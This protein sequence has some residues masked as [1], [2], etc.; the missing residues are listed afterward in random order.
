MIKLITNYNFVF[1]NI[2]ILVINNFSFY[3]FISKLIIIIINNFLSLKLFINKIFFWNDM[4]RSLNY[5]I[6]SIHKGY[7]GMSEKYW[8]MEHNYILL[9]SMV[10]WYSTFQYHTTL[11]VL[12]ICCFLESG[13]SCVVG[14]M[15]LDA[16]QGLFN[17]CSNENK[18]KN[19]Y[20][21]N[22]CYF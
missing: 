4:Y 8:Q 12:L 21:R 9:M 19:F 17:E 13:W 20:E 18:D 15:T 22:E 2:I 10:E 3:K 5:I 1:I 14:K 7:D 6:C 16:T 11:L